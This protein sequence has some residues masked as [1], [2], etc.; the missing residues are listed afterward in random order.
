MTTP[1][2][3]TSS[4]KS[5]LWPPDVVAKIINLLVG[6]AP[7]AASLTRYPTSRAE[8]AFPTAAPDKP[9]WT[10]EG[11]PLPT[12]G[13]HD[14]ADIVAT[15]KLGEIVLLSN[16]SVNDSSVNLTAL[17]G[18]LLADAAGPELDRGLLYGAGA[19]EPVGVVA[20]APAVDGTDLAA[21]LTSAIGAIGDSGGTA[22]HIAAK[23]SVLARQRNVRAAPAGQLL[24]PNGIGAAFGV[25]E[26]GVPSLNDCLLYDASRAWCIVRNDFELAMSMDYA[27]HLDSAAVRVRGR[28]AVGI[29]AINKTIRKLT[30]GGVAPTGETQHAGKRAA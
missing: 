4:F 9:A 27:F 21:A 14:D 10:S 24:F 11:Q 26:V 15:A 18:D 3:T 22:T 13:L 20:N 2:V 28:F 29:P 17:V 12:I 6:G 23:P 5:V 7:F 1:P 8:V 25:T 16:E 19:P 30:V